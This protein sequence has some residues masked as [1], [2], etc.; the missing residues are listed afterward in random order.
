MDP[1]RVLQ[2][3][4]AFNQ[5][6]S[7]SPAAF[8]SSVGGLSSL[9]TVAALARD[10][11]S[12]QM[13]LTAISRLLQGMSEA[14][15]QQLVPYVLAALSVEGG[16]RM[17]LRLFVLGELRRHVKQWQ[18]LLLSPPL[19]PK[20]LSLV[21][22]K[23][24]AATAGR[25]EQAMDAEE[26]DED[27]EDEQDAML[28]LLAP[29]SSLLHE[30]MA[31][32]PAN[33]ELILSDAVISSLLSAAGVASQS[34]L[35]AASSLDSTVL[36]RVFSFYVD[37]ACTS[38]ASLSQFLASSLPSLLLSSL[39]VLASDP[40]S[41][42]NVVELLSRLTRES[43]SLPPAV[44][45]SIL[46]SLLSAPSSSSLLST[47]TLQVAEATALGR[48]GEGDWW[49]D[50]RLLELLE[51]G[52]RGREEVMLVQAVGAVCAMAAMRLDSFVLLAPLC[53]RFLPPL[54][55]S[56]SELP[57][58]AALHGLTLLLASSPDTASAS[59]SPSP[60]SS[61]SSAAA[62]QAVLSLKEELFLSLGPSSSSS[63]Q[64]SSRSTIALLQSIL[65]SPFQ[66]Q[67]IAVFS[68]LTAAAALPSAS[69]L[70]A[71]SSAG[72][73]EW[74]LDRKTETT[75]EG[76]RGKWE[77]LQALAAN[78]LAAAEVDAPVLASAHEY[79]RQGPV[80]VSREAAV[81]P[82]QSKG[83]E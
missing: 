79:V 69:I 72:W 75:T 74:L 1:D 64:A 32:S 70:S 66:P 54:L 40:L 17:E 50:P 22:G 41:Q 30:L 35:P 24:E 68:L 15:L 9:F 37:A 65:R 45:S 63:S 2:A 61:F 16:G 73:V 62:S 38:A 6:P 58:L 59:A 28:Q 51:R 76:M 42:L 20:L 49:R 80:W 78:P 23:Q 29:A 25:A 19:L 14:E 21:A 33:S 67:R 36:L 46:S 52:L 5:A 44:C 13:T 7:A 53:L 57:Q 8:L 56:T 60:A 12:L 81:M 4:H 10:R 26:D 43:P 18:R 55:C 82:P 11:L 39:S 27:D 34:S 47:A 48:K 3:V 31:L 83:D 77:L 71:L